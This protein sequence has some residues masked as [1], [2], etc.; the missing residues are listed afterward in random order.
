[1]KLVQRKLDPMKETSNWKKE[2]VAILKTK[3]AKIFLAIVF[4]VVVLRVGV[5]WYIHRARKA[6]IPRVS[7]FKPEKGIMDQ[8]VTLPGNFEA[9]EQSN[10]FAHVGGYLKKIY[11][12]EGDHVKK[13]QLLA[14]IDAPDVVQEYH[15]AKAEY[16][17]KDITYKRYQEL[18]KEQ[19]VSQQEFDN[20]EADANESKARFD[21][22]AANLSFTRI[23]APFAGSIARRFKYPGDLITNVKSNNEKPLFILINEKDLR[24][25]INVPQIEVSL[26]HPGDAVDIQ[27]DSFSGTTFQGTVTRLDALLD[28]STKTQRVLI[29]LPNPDEKLHAGMFASAVLHV[30]EVKDAVSIPE[31]SILTEGDKHFV[32]IEKD[33]KAIRREVTTGLDLNG[34][35]QITQGV[36]PDDN[37]IR[38]GSAVLTDGSPV[39]PTE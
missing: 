27:V 18:L 37:V 39:K 38:V 36:N 26:I 17:L 32:F 1:M 16:D 25:A 15:K 33:Q 21:N 5:N 4:G 23:T 11:V 13:G 20:V 34:R 2:V 8:T 10:L 28:D 31:D 6:D 30:K 19:V 3:P 12:D 24:L 35:V 22:A 29:D 9:L 7:I 14:E